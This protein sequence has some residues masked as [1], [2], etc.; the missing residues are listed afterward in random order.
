[1]NIL[2][3]TNRYSRCA[4]G[5]ALLLLG[6]CS[7]TPYWDAH[8]GEAVELTKAQQIINPNA[9]QN[10]DPVAG[11]DG[12]AARESVESYE[13]SFRAPAQQGSPFVIGVGSG[14]TSSGQ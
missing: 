7:S 10:P 8:F 11:V 13:R 3:H 5:L 1:M 2:R 12:R 9:G 6:G 4:G 14:S